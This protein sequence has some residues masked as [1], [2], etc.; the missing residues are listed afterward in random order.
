MIM[1]YHL[2]CDKKSFLYKEMIKQRAIETQIILSRLLPE[3]SLSQ[4]IE[5][6]SKR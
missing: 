2:I 3:S 1:I 5:R 4:L 6:D